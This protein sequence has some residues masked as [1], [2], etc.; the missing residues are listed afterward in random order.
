MPQVSVIIPTYNSARYLPA[1]IDSALAQTLR[2]FEL[3]V[4]DDGS[5]DETAAILCS[6]GDR[7][8]ALHQDNRER[9]AARNAGIRAASGEFIAFLDADDLWLPDKLDRQVAALRDHPEVVLV[10]C[11]A[12]YIDTEGRPTRFRGKDK[13]GDN[14][15]DLVIADR[16]RDLL[17]GNVVAG[18][19]S[20]PVVRR[21]AL[22]IS[23]LFD[24]SLIYPEDWGLWTRL[25]RL[26]PFA[27]I[28]QPLAC[29]RVYGEEKVLRL[30]ASDALLAQHLRIVDQALTGWPGDAEELQR[31]RA[32]ATA[33]AYIRSA[34]ASYQIGQ[35]HQ[36][37]AQLAQ[38]IVA[39]PELALRSRL[40]RLA[41]DRA[42][43]IEGETGAYSPAEA[44]IRSFFANLP[45]NARSA[46]GAER[47]AIGWLYITGAFEQHR[48]GNAHQVRMLILRGA[49]RSPEA[50]RNPGVISIGAEAWLGSTITAAARRIRRRL[51]GSG[52]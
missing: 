41:V 21:R 34:L 31:L 44:F 19:G 50:L 14:A 9:S 37:K 29:Y 49:A 5:T 28:P 43:Q 3:I 20:T 47:E 18:G 30:E 1:A 15:S 35:M 23:G 4:V 17:L 13:S 46:A 48:Q 26:G 2:D 6:Y 40:L 22:D 12:A 16:T 39:D 8:L 51:S 32:Q 45:A 25:A 11:Q 24:E 10:Y 7:L 42:K 52:I 38:A 33:A 36:G 27:Y